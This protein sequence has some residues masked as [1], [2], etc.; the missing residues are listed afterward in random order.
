VGTDPRRA[1][2]TA[3]MTLAV[4]VAAAF[5]L[6]SVRR[7]TWPGLPY[8]VAVAAV[9]AV[10]AAA[11]ARFAGDTW[12]PEAIVAGAVLLAVALAGILIV[13]L[14]FLGAPALAWDC[15]THRDQD[16]LSLAEADRVIKWRTGGEAPKERHVR[17]RANIVFP[18]ANRP[19][20]PLQR[21]IAEVCDTDG[22]P[23]RKGFLVVEALEHRLT[24]QPYEVTGEGPASTPAEPILVDY[25]SEAD[26]AAVP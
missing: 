2:L 20:G 24:I 16:Q 6:D 13:H 7:R 10:V 23:F 25:R 9:I 19:S 21:K 5:V 11:V 4:P 14:T 8:K 12:V 1:A 15:H 26:R 3:F 17:R 18:G 22:P